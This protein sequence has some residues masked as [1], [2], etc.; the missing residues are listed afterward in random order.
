MRPQEIYGAN[1]LL[2]DRMCVLYV[3]V[4]ENFY[5]IDFLIVFVACKTDVSLYTKQHLSYTYQDTK[6]VLAQKIN[7]ENFL[8]VRRWRVHFAN[9]RVIIRVC[10]KNL[11]YIP[12]LKRFLLFCLCRN[13]RNSIT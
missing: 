11:L 7:E 8:L 10:L 2:F 5:K 3:E 6:K 9:L 13:Y 4:P 12:F 1:F